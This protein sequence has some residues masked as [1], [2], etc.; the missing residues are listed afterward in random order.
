MSASLWT[1]C[2]NPAGNGTFVPLDASQYASSGRT[3]AYFSLSSSKE[4][5]PSFQYL[6][7]LFVAKKPTTRRV[8]I[9]QF[10]FNIEPHQDPFHHL[11]HTEL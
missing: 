4:P 3:I 5:G 7:M 10:V 1:Q 2:G 8:N 6:Q 9:D 11:L